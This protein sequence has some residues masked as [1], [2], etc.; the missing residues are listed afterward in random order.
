MT[1]Q[2]KQE[3]LLKRLN[4]LA[5][6]A[7]EPLGLSVLTVRLGQQGAKRTL[8]VCIARRHGVVG[9]SDCEQVSRAL[10]QLLEGYSDTSQSILSG[11]YLLE[12][13]SPGI[14]R[15]LSSSDD[16]EIFAGERIRIK[17]KENIGNLGADFTCTLVEGDANSLTV[18]AAEPLVD[19]GRK[20]AK[21]KEASKDKLSQRSKACLP[22]V[23]GA[24]GD[25]FKLDLA[26]VFKINLYSDDL[27]KSKH[28]SE[29]GE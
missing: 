2:P 3:E 5:K 6:S 22:A 26:K 17:A 4:E 11:A 15:Q 25:Q 24:N 13:V 10:D 7:A 20:V 1:I 27:K 28:R 12:V 21:S 8:E 19:T 16:F 23:Q 29:I 14:D 9:L 18:K